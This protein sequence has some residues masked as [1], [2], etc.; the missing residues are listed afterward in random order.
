MNNL[1]EFWKVLCDI[2]PH[3]VAGNFRESNTVFDQ[4][5]KAEFTAATFFLTPK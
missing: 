1:H 3:T 5:R 4:P 2:G